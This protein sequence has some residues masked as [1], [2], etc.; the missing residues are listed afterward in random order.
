MHY[1]QGTVYRTEYQLQRIGNDGGNV[2][3]SQN[4]VGPINDHIESERSPYA[5]LPALT[6]QL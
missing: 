6:E 5:S 2:G 3:I 4:Q 1:N